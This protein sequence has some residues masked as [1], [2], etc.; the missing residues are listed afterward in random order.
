MTN[1]KYNFVCMVFQKNDFENLLGIHVFTVN[2]D[3]KN[4]YMWNFIK[5]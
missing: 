2:F 1:I 4:F 3:L 5:E